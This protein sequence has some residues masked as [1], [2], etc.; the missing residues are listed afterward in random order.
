[1]TRKQ[2]IAF[3]RANPL[4]SAATISA[5]GAPQAAILGVA[6]S[7]RLELVFDTLDTS[8]KFLNLRA[9]PKIAIVFG[10]AGAYESG[11]HDE[12]TVQYEGTADVPHSDELKRVQDSIYFQQFPDGRSRMSWPHIAYVRVRPAWIR[13]SDYDASPPEIV[14]LVDLALAKFIAEP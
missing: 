2:L 10:A 5:A 14:E 1:M 9:N 8:R 4:V 12:R 7:D 13:F 6:V 3:M 11:E